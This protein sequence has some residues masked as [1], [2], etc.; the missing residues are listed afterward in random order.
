MEKIEFTEHNMERFKNIVQKYEIKNSALLPTMYLAQEQFGY[1]SNEVLLYVAKILDLPAREVFEAASFYVFF[2]LKKMRY[3]LSV[4]NNIT[5][6]M[7]GSEKLSRRIY[8]LLTIRHDEVTD[9]NIFGMKHVQCLG[10]CNTAPVVQVNEDYYEHMDEK[11]LE[12]LI[13]TLRERSEKT[14]L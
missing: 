8:E 1:L 7:F 11:K 3:C 9:D 12:D 14:S 6:S 13:T 10:S 2:K 4:C 5:C